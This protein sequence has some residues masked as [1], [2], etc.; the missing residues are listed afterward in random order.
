M[1]KLGLPRLCWPPPQMGL[2]EL[3]VSPEGERAGSLGQDMARSD[4]KAPPFRPPAFPPL[5]LRSAVTGLF[6]AGR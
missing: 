4:A 3:S 6:F 1:Q 2:E 5:P